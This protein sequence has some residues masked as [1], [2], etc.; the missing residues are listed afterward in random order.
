MNRYNLLCIVYACLGSVFY[1][2]DSGCTTS[3][4]GYPAFLE[5]FNLN[6]VTIGAFG[7]A[8]YGGHVLGA[9]L[10]F[11]LPN[12]I[13]RLRTIQIACVISFLGISMQVGA[14]SFPVFCAGRIIGGTATGIMF[15][16]CPTYVSE[17]SPPHIRGRVGG[18]YAFNGNFSYMFTEWVGLGCFFLKSNASW[19]LLLGGQ[20]VPSVLM[21]GLSFFMPFSPRWLALKGR[22]E[23]CLQVLKRMHGDMHDD[24]FYLKEYHQIKAQIELDKK[25][26]L[27]PSAIWRVPSYRKRIFLV[28]MFAFCSQLTGEIPLQNYQVILFGKLGLS[29][30]MSLVLTG[31]WGSVGVCS[32]IYAGY[33]SDKLGRRKIIY[34]MYFFVLSGSLISVVLWSRFEAG[35]STN[36]G[37]GRGVIVGM[38]MVQFGYAGPANVF[39]PAVSFKSLSPSGGGRVHSIF[40]FLYKRNGK[41]NSKNAETTECQ[42]DHDPIFQ[43]SSEIMP[44]AIRSIGVAAT[45]ACLHAIIILLVQVTPLAIDAISWKYFLIFLIGSTIYFIFF[46]FAYPETKNMTLEEIEAV[47]GDK[48]AETLEEAGQHLEEVYEDRAYSEKM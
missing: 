40:S 11:W 30:V 5:Y 13:G 29:Q 4:L 35:G 39:M 32:A 1:G 26:H 15:C 3:V 45:F 42:T 19:R 6:S 16:L 7:S 2:Y 22:Y 9:C 10:N 14:S 21:L 44:T 18:L 31:I 46:C 28:C 47:F 34:I 25:E 41:Q 24:T 33:L 23:E 8:Y 43:Y 37:L 20:L 48:V 36:R 12:K 17:L 38:F 27:G